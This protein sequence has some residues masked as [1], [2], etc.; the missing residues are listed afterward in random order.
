MSVPLNRKANKNFTED[1]RD[2]LRDFIEILEI[3]D[4]TLGGW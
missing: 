4:G 3:I 2:F 1:V